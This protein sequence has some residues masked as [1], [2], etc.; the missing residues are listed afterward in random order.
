MRCARWWRRR[1]RRWLQLLQEL[2]RPSSH[3]TRWSS[4]ARA[5]QG[6]TEFSQ[7]RRRPP[8][9]QRRWRRRVALLPQNP[10]RWALC[11]ADLA[12]TNLNYQPGTPG[13]RCLHMKATTYR[14][15]V[16]SS[17]HPCI[18]AVNKKR[19]KGI[20]WSLYW[21]DLLFSN[22]NGWR[23]GPWQTWKECTSENIYFP[24]SKQSQ[25]LVK[26]VP[27]RQ[28]RW[29]RLLHFAS[30]QCIPMQLNLF[31]LVVVNFGV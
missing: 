15:E 8:P 24:K 20:L 13:N 31:V 11:H 4:F 17:I 3:T 9:R 7:G 1:Q 12:S 5:A 10:N 21:R 30:A 25:G 29:R 19:S 16:P 26:D 6:P 22:N 14:E 2:F 28:Q 18:A 23:C 27:W